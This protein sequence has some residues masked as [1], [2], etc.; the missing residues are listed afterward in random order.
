MLHENNFA[1]KHPSE[2]W[3]DVVFRPITCCALCTHAEP[4]PRFTCDLCNARLCQHCYYTHRI[5]AHGI[6]KHAVTIRQKR[7]RRWHYRALKLGLPGWKLPPLPLR[8]CTGRLT[9]FPDDKSKRLRPGPSRPPTED[10]PQTAGS[11]VFT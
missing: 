7:L 1:D 4:F 10:Q 9:I 5:T 11:E 6:G 8:G 2:P 3:V